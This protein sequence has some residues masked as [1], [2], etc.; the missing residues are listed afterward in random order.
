MF[1]SSQDNFLFL[2]F[3]IL[4]MW[5]CFISFFLFSLFP[6]FSSSLP[7]PPTHCF[8]NYPGCPYL[9][10]KDVYFCCILVCVP[11]WSYVCVCRYCQGPEKSTTP[12]GARVTGICEPPDVGAG[13]QTLI[14]MIDHKCAQMLSHLSCS[15][16]VFK[17]PRISP[18]TFHFYSHPVIDMLGSILCDLQDTEVQSLPF[19][20]ETK[21]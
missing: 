11:V 19:E 5:P 13:A 20:L 16:T 12:L 3:L 15:S 14:F 1:L 10:F 6:S 9:W 17:F 18:L 21:L 4:S 8:G 2:P 7:L